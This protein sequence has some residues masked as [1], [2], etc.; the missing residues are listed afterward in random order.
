[1]S[2]GVL[3]DDK[4]QAWPEGALELGR[5]IGG[6]G[7]AADFP[8][9]ALREH[10]F[11]HL[12]PQ[13]GGV[14]VALCAG[15]F[16]AAALAGLLYV[17]RDLRPRHVLLAVLRSDGWSYAMHVSLWELAG[18][19]EALLDEAP[20]RPAPWVAIEHDLATVSLPSYAR[21]RPLVE[22]WR[23]SRGRLDGDRLHAVTALGLG[24]RTLLA[25]R[26]A[27]AARLAIEHFGAA[28]TVLRPCESLL[29]IGRDIED[30]PDRDYGVW[31][32]RHYHETLM[33]GHPRF[34]SVRAEL[35]AS[36]GTTLRARYD[37]LLVP[38]RGAGD[39]H[40]VMGIS[41]RISAFVLGSSSGSALAQA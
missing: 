19:L 21:V 3:I 39:E 9:R 27:G 28:I 24:D 1:M 2:D 33:V 18:R 23:S 11:I 20:A 29:A 31:A 36:D 10:G 26:P 40:F 13:H 38:W 14:R 12:R 7:P 17:L 30:I 4:G 34:Q 5:R 35:G 41:I 15:A 6:S 25:R 8:E 37:R 22:L 32:A 16:T